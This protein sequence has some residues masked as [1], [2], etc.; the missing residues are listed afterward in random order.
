MKQGFLPVRPEAATHWAI[1]G[2]FVMMAVAAL[3]FAQS[4]FIPVVFALLLALILSPIRRALGKVG[5]GPGFAAGIIMIVFCAISAI[6]L[7]MVS[8]SLA[9]IVS[10]EPQLMNKVQER[11]N[12]MTGVLEPVRQAGQQLEEMQQSAPEAPERVVV[13]E[14]GIFSLW[15]QT[16]PYVAGQVGLAIVLATFLIASGD[17]FYEKLVEVMPNL[18]AKRKALMIARDM[19]RQLSTYF[20]TITGINA[21]LGI[22]VGVAMWLLGMPDPVFFGVAA[23]ALNYIPYV[24]S[25]IGIVFAFMMGVV[26][27][28]NF[29]LSLAPPFA[30]WLINSAEGQFITPVAVGRRLRL[31]AV[32]V[33]L[34]IAFWAWL[35]SFVGMF[36]STPML[37]A[38]KAFSERNSELSW[39][40]TFL[41]GRKP[42]DMEDDQVVQG[43][44]DDGSDACHPNEPQTLEEVEEQ[45]STREQIDEDLERDP[46]AQPSSV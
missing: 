36:L 17:M 39:L 31:N 45:V 2:L 10:D 18:S 7:F 24:G 6:L 34:S 15:A 41:E 29:W 8:S 11:V 23:F 25:I 46:S 43:V 14:E 13:R 4:F 27:Y 30:Y 12:E 40:N 3:S 44:M 19:E 32:A 16:T 1:I 21:A 33:F 5:I 28:D 35:W 20:L 22:L 38:L 42:C 37:I 26:T 9:T